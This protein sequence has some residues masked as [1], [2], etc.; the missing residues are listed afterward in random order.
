MAA[1]IALLRGINVGGNRKVP[2]ADLRVVFA[3]AG[4]DDV[5][6][7]IAS[8]NVVFTH[9]SRSDVALTADLQKHIKEAFG[10]DVDVMLRTASQWRSV[11]KGNPFPDA[12]PKTLHVA[13]LKG[14]PPAGVLDAMDLPR[15]APEELLLNGKEAYLHLPN[16]LGTSKLAA[17]LGKLKTPATARNW[18][19]VMKLADLVKA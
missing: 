13:F 3:A 18:Q 15:F 5:V 11:I 10:F 12:A 4:C 17:S 8:G 6:T 19:T 1:R 16:G 14:K 7:Y 2:M 9:P